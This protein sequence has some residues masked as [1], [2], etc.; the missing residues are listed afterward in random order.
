M[1]QACDG[2]RSLEA[3]ALGQEDI[4]AL[5]HALTEGGRNLGPLCAA[6]ATLPGSTRAK[7]SRNHKLATGDPV[8]RT[9]GC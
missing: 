8:S 7:G 3:G 6:L 1:L 9:L 4:V 5:E 2:M